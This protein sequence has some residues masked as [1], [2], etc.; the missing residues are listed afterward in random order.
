M[1]PALVVL[2]AVDSAGLADLVVDTVGVVVGPAG[3]VDGGSVAA[4]EVAGR[5]DPTDDLVD[6][7]DPADP[8][9]K[10]RKIKIL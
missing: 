5:V 4:A 1:K 9:Q 6:P 8:V 2:V 3:G 7:A 10:Q